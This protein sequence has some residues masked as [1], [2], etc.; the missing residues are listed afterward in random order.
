MRDLQEG[1]QPSVMVYLDGLR[2]PGN[3]GGIIRTS[4]AFGASAVVLGKDTADPFSAK[5]VRA[6]AG[7]VFHTPLFYGIGFEGLKDLK[8]KGFSIF[9]AEAGGRDIREVRFPERSILV[10]GSEAHGFSREIRGIGQPVGVKLVPGVDSLNV[11]VAGS[12]I[13]ERMMADSS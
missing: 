5:A 4:W 13:L 9:L 7:G 8:E 6:S 3:V 10:L 2:E 12:I 1:L 11:V